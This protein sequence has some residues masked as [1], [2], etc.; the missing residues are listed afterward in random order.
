MK[1]ILIIFGAK[2]LIFLSLVISGV[3][4]LYQPWNKKMDIVVVGFYTVIL[5]GIMALVAGHFYYNPRPFVTRSFTPLIP[6]APDNGF[7]SDHV[8]LASF[9]AVILSF[10]NRKIAGILWILTIFIAICRVLSGV[11]HPIDVIGSIAI[12][13]LSTSITYIIIRHASFKKT[14]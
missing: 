7:P 8:L 4:F 12:S 14:N 11:H 2:Y 3:Y 1:E 9:T 5:L 13:I 6:H 10:Y